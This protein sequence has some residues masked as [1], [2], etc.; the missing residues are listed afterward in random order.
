M[1]RPLLLCLGFL[2]L[3]LLCGC[4]AASTPPPQSE[5]GM[6]EVLDVLLTRCSPPIRG[7]LDRYVTAVGQRLADAIDRGAPPPRW[8]FRVL[9]LDT[10]NAWAAPAGG[11]YVTRG[12]LVHLDSEAELAT[13]LAHEMGHVVAGHGRDPAQALGANPQGD[14]LGRWV[15]Y[16]RDEERQADEWAV[17]LAQRAGYDGRAAASMLRSLHR[18]QGV[19]FGEGEAAW[20]TSWADRHPPL[21]VRVARSEVL[22]R[23]GGVRRRARFLAQLEG[24]PIARDADVHQEPLTGLRFPL[25]WSSPNDRCQLRVA[26][27]R[28]FSY[29]DPDAALPGE[30]ARVVVEGE[31]ARL[32]VV[33]HGARVEFH[34][35]DEVGLR[36]MALTLRYEPVPGFRLRTCEVPAG[37]AVGDACGTLDPTVTRRLGTSLEPAEDPRRVRVAV[38]VADTRAPNRGL[39]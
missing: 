6:G 8:R 33:R 10:P 3:G 17:Q 34:A 5:R 13:V 36:A 35:R 22:A 27:E 31:L 15:S 9:D 38:R 39:R 7:E 26:G 12:L 30:G 19:G 25:G 11:I 23:P 28:S 37:R 20:E 32:E 14:A 4:G 2:C 21:A 16:Q 29:G 1:S 24:L 18:A